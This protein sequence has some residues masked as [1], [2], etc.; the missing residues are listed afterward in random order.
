MNNRI[1]AIIVLFFAVTSCQLEVPV[2][3][4]SESFTEASFEVCKTISCPELT[5]NYV[6]AMDDTKASERINEAIK[7]HIITAL[8]IGDDSISKAKTISEAASEFIK[9]YRLHS[10]EF[11]D[12]SAEYFAEINIVESYRSPKMT[13]IEMRDYLYTGGAHGYGHVTFLNVRS[14]NGAEI[15]SEELLKN[16]EAFTTFAETK[17]REAHSIPKN[18]SIN[19]TGFWFEDEKFALPETIGFT[20]DTLLLL[21]NQYEIASYADGPIELSIPLDE[22]APFLAI[23]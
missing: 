22:A 19:S 11:P 1:L 4:S 13:S 6:E 12:M 15:T 3:F 8:H 21:Y 7:K 17:F 23:K 2:N 9:T 14:K 10:A 16:R 18:E 5:I 20:K